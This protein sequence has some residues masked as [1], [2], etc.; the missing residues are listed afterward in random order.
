MEQE[1]HD[2]RWK[3]AVQS[4]FS[5]AVDLMLPKLLPLFNFPRLEWVTQEIFPTLPR[6]PVVP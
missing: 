2:Q 4:K 3:V 6:D 5:D 1:D